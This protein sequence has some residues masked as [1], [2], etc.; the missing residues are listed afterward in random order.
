LLARELKR[1]C[2]PVAEKR[3]GADGAGVDSG[4]CTPSLPERWTD[5][6]YA[7]DKIPVDICVGEDTRCWRP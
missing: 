4:R 6:A 2:P 3:R 1:A 7:G 5:S